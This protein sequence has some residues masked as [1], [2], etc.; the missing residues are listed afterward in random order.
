M[1]PVVQNRYSVAYQHSLPSDAT[2]LFWCV[3]FQALCRR[4]LESNFSGVHDYTDEYACFAEI[5]QDLE[6][7]I[8]ITSLSGS[9]LAQQAAEIKEMH[10]KR[11]TT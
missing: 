7:P 6:L 10:M 3:V 5:L 1:V 4:R 2:H 11:G 9:G 8:P